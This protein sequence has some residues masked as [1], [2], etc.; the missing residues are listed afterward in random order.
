MR[1]I[2]IS[3]AYFFHYEI[4]ESC[5]PFGISNDIDMLHLDTSRYFTVILYFHNSIIRS[6]LFSQARLISVK[7][8][9]EIPKSRAE[10]T[11]A[12]CRVWRNESN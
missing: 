6:I 2:S 11:L 5:P 10:N 3:H 9:F 8:N 7:T 1:L 12:Q 4:E